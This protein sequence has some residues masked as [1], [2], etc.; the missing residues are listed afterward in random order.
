MHD[1]EPD[2][3]PKNASLINQVRRHARVLHIAKRTE[4]AYVGWITRLLVFHRN[5]RGEWVHPIQLGSQEVNEFLTYLAVERKVAASTQNQA[6][7]A[8]LFLYSKILKVDS[9][10]EAVRAKKP[11]KLPVVLSTIE[12]A[13]AG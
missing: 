8:L 6:L 13:R 2:P 4:E 12:V 1:S 10:L 11:S 3:P 7:S 9:R 5:Q